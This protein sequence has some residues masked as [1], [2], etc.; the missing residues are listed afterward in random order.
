MSK[1]ENRKGIRCH[2]KRVLFN[3][4][5]STTPHK[6]MV[7]VPKQLNKV[8][9]LLQTNSQLPQSERFKIAETRSLKQLINLDQYQVFLLFKINEVVTP[10]NFNQTIINSRKPK[11]FLRNRLSNPINSKKNPLKQHFNRTE[12][13]KQ[14]KTLEYKIP[15]YSEVTMSI[16]QDLKLTICKKNL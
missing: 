6:N 2:K 3:N 10:I 8:P 11:K 15:K 12:Y 16:I 13:R 9:S 5:I 1:L 7:P 14:L 4:T